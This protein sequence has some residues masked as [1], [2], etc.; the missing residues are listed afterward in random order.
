MQRQVP[1]CC[2]ICCSRWVLQNMVTKQQICSLKPKKAVLRGKR[3]FSFG[4]HGG[5]VLASDFQSS[6]Q[7]QYSVDFE[8]FNP[9]VLPNTTTNV[10][11]KTILTEPGEKGVIFLVIGLVNGFYH[12]FQVNA[13]RSLGKR[14]LF[15]VCTL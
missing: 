9:V 15:F 12:I 2:R 14:S 13:T 6:T 5:F 11:I 1:G 10:D 3:R 4:D 8:N 7:L